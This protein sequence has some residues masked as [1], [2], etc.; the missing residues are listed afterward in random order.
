MAS[1]CSVTFQLA[2]HA[3]RV[4]AGHHECRQHRSQLA[5]QGDGN[6][7]ACLADLPVIRQRARHLQRHHRPAEEPGQDRDGETAD[8][9]DIHL[10]RDIVAV[11]GAA[12]DVL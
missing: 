2:G 5:H 8:S 3:G 9:D 4:A 12:E 1:I 11:M 7:G 10:E 6:Q